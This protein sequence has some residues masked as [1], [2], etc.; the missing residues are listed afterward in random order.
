M[1]YNIYENE[2]YLGFYEGIVNTC[3]NVRKLSVKNPEKKYRIKMESG[4]LIGTYF[5][6]YLY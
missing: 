2:S 1:R 6:G 5:D 3:I 4:I